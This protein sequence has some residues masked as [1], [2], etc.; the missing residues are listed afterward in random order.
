MQ[1]PQTFAHQTAFGLPSPASLGA[2]SPATL[3]PLQHLQIANY[4]T[5]IPKQEAF[6]HPLLHHFPSPGQLSY[7]GY[8]DAPHTTPVGPYPVSN[9]LAP[10]PTHHMAAPAPTSHRGN[11]DE[12]T[13]PFDNF[14]FV[15]SGE[16]TCGGHQVQPDIFAQTGRGYFINEEGEW[17]CYRR[18]Y[19]LVGCSY[20]LTPL[21]QGGILML[22]GR[23]VQALGLRLTASQD[24]THGK[25]VELVKYTAKRDQGKKTPVYL[26]K[27]L[28]CPIEDTFLAASALQQTERGLYSR[29]STSFTHPGSYAVPSLPS[30][31]TVQLNPGESP[32]PQTSPTSSEYPYSPLSASQVPLPGNNTQHTFERIQFK[33]ATANNGKR[34]A[35]Q[36]FYHLVVELHADT[37]APGAAE[38]NWEKVAKRMCARLVVRGRSPSHYKDLLNGPNAPGRKGGRG[39][40]G[41]GGR[42]SGS[43]SS[44]HPYSPPSTLPRS[45]QD[46]SR[47]GHVNYGGFRAAQRWE[48]PQPQS[49]FAIGRIEPNECLAPLPFEN[50]KAPIPFENMVIN[51]RGYL[52]FND[53]DH[54]YS[55]APRQPV[56]EDDNTEGD[57]D[58]TVKSES[59]L[60]YFEPEP[61]Y[62][63][64]PLPSDWSDPSTHVDTKD[65]SRGHYLSELSYS[66]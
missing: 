17:T 5:Y 30:Q 64:Y 52:E 25:T 37:R 15:R 20:T 8:P 63:E 53:Q 48:L 19:F 38:P 43:A 60:G 21:T 14:E 47:G 59:P 42:S 57:N 16:L 54:T 49:T 50:T 24:G 7:P 44:H 29:P 27:C 11:A 13:P 6:P 41:G 45:I 12:T 35:S 4:P 28:P 55:Y 3:P 40:G 39:G 46:S 18:N 22:G 31:N 61:V 51:I 33:S 36:Q 58:D 1:Q 26:V 10:L 66:Y 65:S 9:L 32:E 2:S 23:Q 34:R 62:A 56:E